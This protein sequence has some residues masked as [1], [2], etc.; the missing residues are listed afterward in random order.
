MKKQ[1]GKEAETVSKMRDAVRIA[2]EVVKDEPEPY[3][4]EAFRTV[5]AKLLES[6]EG[7][8]SVGG[9]EPMKIDRRAKPSP[10]GIEKL[11]EACSISRPQLEDIVNTENGVV[12]FLVP[13]DRTASEREKQIVASQGILVTYHMALSKEWI[14]A[15]VLVE[16]LKNAG[17][18]S[19]RELSRY[20]STRSDLFMKRGEGKYREYKLTETGKKAAFLTIRAL[21]EDR[22]E[23]ALAAARGET[24]GQ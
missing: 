4:A 7:S 5:L 6:I 17:I 24:G 8:T 20:L 18:G 19:I 3:R 22:I 14:E 9:I 21:S 16:A 2:K 15:S 10:N 1:G 13:L 23:E 11:A 12:R